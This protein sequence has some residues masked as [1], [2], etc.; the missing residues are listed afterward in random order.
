MDEFNFES[1]IGEGATAK[2]LLVTHKHSKLPFAIKVVCK[3][4]VKAMSNQYIE[5]YL[6]LK[7]ATK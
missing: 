7:I 4:K 6:M 3:K 2:V 5:P 1:F